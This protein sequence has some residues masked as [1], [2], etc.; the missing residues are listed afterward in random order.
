MPVGCEAKI[1]L[2][3]NFDNGKSRL[4]RARSGRSR[5]VVRLS[6]G[7][8]GF[9]PSVPRRE[10]NESP[11]GTGSITETIKVRL[12]AEACLPGT[13][14]SNPFRV[15]EA[16]GRAESYGFVSVPLSCA[17]RL[18]VTKPE[19]TGGQQPDIQP[20]AS[21]VLCEPYFVPRTIATILYCAWRRLMPSRRP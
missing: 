5:K 8:N 16:R 19:N 21:R 10:R 20:P 11:S 13:D 6:A 15:S 7:G 14:G 4:A 1:A 3:A 2:L 9:E 17:G 18:F 12:E